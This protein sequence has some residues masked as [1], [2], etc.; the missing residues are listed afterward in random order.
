LERNWWYT[1]AFVTPRASA[2]I[3]NE[4]PLTPCSPNRSSAAAIVRR[5]TALCSAPVVL[6]F[7]D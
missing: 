1:A 3:C 7:G 5:C 2:I 4:V 6:T